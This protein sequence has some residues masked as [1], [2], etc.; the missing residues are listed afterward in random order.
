MW[1]QDLLW[2]LWNGVTAWIVWA[3]H[4]FGFWENQPVYDVL[5]AGGWYDLGFLFGAGSPFLGTLG[6]KSGN[7]RR[8][9][10]GDTTSP[11]DS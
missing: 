5:R 1:W 11:P 4:L 3:A 8:A 7:S 2:G 6:G 9:S 10:S